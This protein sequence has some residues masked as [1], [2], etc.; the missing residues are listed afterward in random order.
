MVV[1]FGDLAGTGATDILE[2]D[3]DPA[4][5]EPVPRHLRETM[6]AALPFI[7]ERFPTHRAWSR[8]TIADIAGQRPGQLQKL[9]VSTLASTVFLNRQ[10]KFEARPLPLEA[11]MAPVFSVNVADLDGDGLED[12]FVTQNFFAFR[13]EEARLDG[14]RSLW[15]RG[16][17]RG[18]LLPV[19]GQSSGLLVYGEQRGAALADFNRD[20]RTDLVVTQNGAATRLFQNTGA[21]PGLRVR[22]QGPAANPDGVGA[23]LRLRFPTGWGPARE[24]HAGDGYWSQSSPTAVL[25]LREPP[26]ALQVRWPGGRTAEHPVPENARE[27]G[28]A[29]PAQR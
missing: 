24:I 5:Q 16:D 20:A 15:L 23:V 8:A 27:V 4:R 6:Q 19:P 13:D 11:Q 3:W 2:T 14:G 7:A 22:L 21:R 9:S 1:Y 25:G 29:N 26:L 12:L 17:G 28:I 18:N 10:G